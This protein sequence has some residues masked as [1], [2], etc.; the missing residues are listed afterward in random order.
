MTTKLHSSYFRALSILIFLLISLS[1][2][3]FTAYA[4]ESTGIVLK[5]N[6]IIL[7]V[8]KSHQLQWEVLPSSV[9]QNAV[10]YSKDA[11][12]A[13]VSD[14]GLIIAVSE[15]STEIVITSDDG[16]SFSTCKV[17]VTENKDTEVIALK[18]NSLLIRKGSF[19]PLF[20]TYN[21]G[22]FVFT[23]TATFSSSDESVATVSSDGIIKAIDEGTATISAT[24][25]KTTKKCT[26]HVGEGSKYISGH[27]ITG[28][29]IDSSNKLYKN[30]TIALSAKS[31]KSTYYATV[32]TDSFGKFMF[33]GIKNGSYTL[34]YY[35]TSKKKIIKSNEIEVSGKDITITSILNNG[36]LLTIDG[37]LKSSENT[38]PKTVSLPDEY[39][40]MNIG[41]IKAIDIITTPRD[42][43]ISKLKVTSSDK[44]V[45][46]I[47]DKGEF[48]AIKDGYADITYTT[49]DG[50]STATCRVTVLENESTQ[51]SMLYIAI[52]VLIVLI[53]LLCFNRK[54]K[55]F[56]IQKRRR[57][58]MLE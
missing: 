31:G 29:L 48:V 25:G 19:S 23:K 7:T 53:I 32:K 3:Q 33:N 10:L 34:A 13:N 14:G 42:A 21:K 8:G 18:D 36:T 16:M 39:L 15:G 45:V 22:E 20:Y 41:D 40:S 55:K 44:S 58:D 56:L 4:E 57:E 9:S 26:V 1:A 28:T 17:T 52:I 46:D 50:K 6:N 24:F 27:S 2:I 5:E 12:V 43:D 37:E 49:P 30:K 47:N 51:Y 11:S 35:D 54:Y 38:T